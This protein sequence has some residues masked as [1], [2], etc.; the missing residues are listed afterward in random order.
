MVEM[1]IQVLGFKSAG[2]M[3]SARMLTRRNGAAADQE[4]LRILY[5]S[6]SGPATPGE[7]RS[8]IA[9]ARGDGGRIIN[10]EC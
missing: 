2:T 8:R 9:G 10:P 6:A 1:G 5:A 3:N 7:N 4:L